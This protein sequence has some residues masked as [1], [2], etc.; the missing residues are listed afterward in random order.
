MTFGRLWRWL[1]TCDEP[2]CDEHPVHLG[3]CAVHAPPYE[4]GPD[5]YWGDRDEEV[6]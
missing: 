5:E 6:R 1:T 4:P 2:G 3:W